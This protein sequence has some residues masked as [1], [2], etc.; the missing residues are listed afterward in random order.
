M[1][2]NHIKKSHPLEFYIYAFFEIK[3]SLT[4]CFSM[5]LYINNQ[6]NQIRIVCNT[7]VLCNIAYY[8]TFSY[9]Y[10]SI[11]IQMKKENFVGRK[12]KTYNFRKLLGSGAF[13]DVYEAIDDRDSNTIAIKVVPSI[14][15]KQT[16]KLD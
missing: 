6:I 5:P 4:F 2:S 12:I 1:A 16:P 11:I 3:K 13:A 8:K 14:L 9:I 7:L 15:L 10:I